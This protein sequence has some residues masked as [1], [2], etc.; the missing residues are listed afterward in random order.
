MSDIMPFAYHDKPVRVVKIENVSWFVAKDVCAC[1]EIAWTGNQTLAKI[2]EHWKRGQEI[3]DPFSKNPQNTIIINEPAV[4]KL[5]FRSHKPEAEAF[6]NWV[7]EDVLPQIRQTGRYEHPNS[8][9][10]YAELFQVATLQAEVIRL[11]KKCDTLQERVDALPLRGG[12]HRAFTQPEIHEMLE[13]KRQ[14][15]TVAAIANKLHRHHNTIWKMLR[16]L[17]DE[18]AADP[19]KTHLAFLQEQYRLK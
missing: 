2:P 5:A 9:P 17:R 16:R 14:G 1:L 10:E 18:Y 15:M 8:Q 4:Y 12:R 6:T 11:M 19:T 3:P 13:L 7:A